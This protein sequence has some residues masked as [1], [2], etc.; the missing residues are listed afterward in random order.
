MQKPILV[1]ITGGSGSGKS[2][3]ANA[4]CEA[5]GSNDIAKIE[6]DFLSYQYLR[7]VSFQWKIGLR[8]IMI[9]LMLLIMIF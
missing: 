9:I 2:S 3:I 7:A 1:G 4:I 8:L 5:F 6:Q